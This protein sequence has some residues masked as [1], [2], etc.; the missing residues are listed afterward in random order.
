MNFL[1]FVTDAFEQGF[2]R[3]ARDTNADF[4]CVAGFDDFGTGAGSLEYYAIFP[5][6]IAVDSF[7]HFDDEAGEHPFGHEFIIVA[8]DKVISVVPVVFGLVGGEELRSDVGFGAV[9]NFVAEF[10]PHHQLQQFIAHVGILRIS[11]DDGEISLCE[12]AEVGADFGGVEDF[13]DG[14]STPFGLKDD[15][16]FEDGVVLEVEA[17][18]EVM[19]V[20]AELEFVLA[21]LEALGVTEDQ[22]FILADMVARFIFYCF[23][24]IDPGFGQWGADVGKLADVVLN[25]SKDFGQAAIGSEVGGQDFFQVRETTAQLVL[26]NLAGTLLFLVFDDE[27]GASFAEQFHNF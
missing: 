3:V 24:D 9:R 15:D 1:E 26:I 17:N 20:A 27:G 5:N 19:E 2:L 11:P 18:A 25:G 10:E 8:Q 13:I 16:M 22:K 21:T 6:K 4:F 7:V 23:T 14:G 12:T